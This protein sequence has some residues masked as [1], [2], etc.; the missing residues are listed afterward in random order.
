MLVIVVRDQFTKV[1]TI[2]LPS[3][4][5]NGGNGCLVGVISTLNDDYCYICNRFLSRKM[6]PKR[7][8]YS[9]MV[10]AAALMVAALPSRAYN[11]H[12]GHNLDSLERAVARWT[13]DAVDRAS[14][15]ELAHLNMD[16]RNLMLGYQSLNQEKFMFYARKALEISSRQGWDLANS[17]ALRH[18]G[19]YFWHFNQLDSALIYYTS[20]LECVDRMEA[21][22]TSFSNPDGYSEVEI[23]DQRSVLLATIGNLYNVMDSIPRAMEYYHKAGKLFEK[24]GWDQSNSVLWHN[25]GETWVEQREFPKAKEAYD[26]SLSFAEAADDSLMI[27]DAWKGYGHMYLAKGLAWKALPLLRKADA[28]YA[29]KDNYR[30]EWRAEVLDY[31][32]EALSLQKRQLAWIISA[33]V[34]LLAVV[35]VISVRKRKQRSTPPE[36]AVAP[37]TPPA[38]LKL[39]DREMDILNLLAKA[40]TSKQ[41][42]EALFLS[43]ETI[44]WYRKKLLVKFD[45]ANTPELVLKAKEIGLI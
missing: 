1:P 29:T 42:A 34:V 10:A 31:I 37:V 2:M 6:S 17:E 44:N 24:H 15:A 11:D 30:P 8:T 12:R 40:Y 13:P 32:K 22:A 19:Q 41:I 3:T 18:I 36:E 43:P 4:T 28:Y 23:D 5:N 27:A 9:A 14:Q 25:I 20:A 21:G 45:V 38:D 16:Y 39:T 7:R 26:K 33:F 35:I